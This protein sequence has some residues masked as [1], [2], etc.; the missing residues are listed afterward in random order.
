M[1]P[2]NRE[3]LYSK[4]SVSQ[5]LQVRFPLYKTTFLSNLML[6][7]TKHDSENYICT[8]GKKWIGCDHDCQS[9]LI[10]IS[11]VETVN[12]QYLLDTSA[13]TESNT[14]PALW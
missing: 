10:D 1:D 14:N 9:H 5:A 3:F 11:F 7:K 13:E 2:L 6:T 12:K 4:Y 8:E